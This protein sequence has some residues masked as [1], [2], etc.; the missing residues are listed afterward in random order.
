MERLGGCE[1]TGKSSGLAS[2]SL[3]TLQCVNS[4]A[5]CGKKL[6]KNSNKKQTTEKNQARK[7]KT[8][9]I[10]FDELRAKFA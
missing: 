9:M 4:I 1:E 5:Q 7:Q 10:N 6:G 2:T 8:A 3:V